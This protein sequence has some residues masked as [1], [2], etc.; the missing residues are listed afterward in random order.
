MKF[1]LRPSREEIL[2]THLRIWI[3][4]SMRLAQDNATKDHMIDDL[5]FTIAHLLDNQINQ[6]CT[7][8]MQ[9]KTQKPYKPYT[10]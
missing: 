9:P 1:W 7:E 2:Q 3:E 5:D 4:I 6:H 10:Y 8:V